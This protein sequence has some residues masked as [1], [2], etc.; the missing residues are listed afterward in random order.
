M[1]E[2]P[3]DAENQQTH[4]TYG[5]RV[6]HEIVKKA[7]ANSLDGSGLLWI[8]LSLQIILARQP[9][10]AVKALPETE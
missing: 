4:S 1:T 7:A 10:T 2:L 8:T 6:R 5:K 3:E 9:L